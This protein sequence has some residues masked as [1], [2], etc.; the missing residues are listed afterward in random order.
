MT[1]TLSESALQP[2]AYVPPATMNHPKATMNLARGEVLGFGV[3]VVQPNGG[4]TNLHAHAAAES[5]WF[6]LKGRAR[7]YDTEDHLFGE[8]GPMEGVAI[9]RAA[10]Y[11]FE[12][13]DGDENLEIGHVTVVNK[14]A[15][16]HR[17]NFSPLVERQAG[18]HTEAKSRDLSK[19]NAKPMHSVKYDSPAL[20]GEVMKVTQLWDGGDMLQF[21]VEKIGSGGGNPGLHS[22]TGSEGAW[23]VLCGAVRFTDKAGVIFELSANEGVFIPVGEAYG[24]ESIGEEPLEILHIKARDVRI[25]SSERLDID[26][27]SRGAADKVS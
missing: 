9:P 17:L 5:L 26:P 2:F 22:H 21:S 8:Y 7:F 6:V 11:W 27:L 1:Q 4:E 19:H 24:F 3:Q 20:D 10:P 13:A 23:F 14:N 12:A 15:Q 18:R 16:N 25:E